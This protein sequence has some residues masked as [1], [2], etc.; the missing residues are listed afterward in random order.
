MCFSIGIFRICPANSW[1]IY[2]FCYVSIKFLFK[3]F[4][5]SCIWHT[6]QA[7][8]WHMSK[9]CQMLFCK[10]YKQSLTNSF[11]L[12]L[13]SP[14]WKSVPRNWLV[15]PSFRMPLSFCCNLWAKDVY[16]CYFFPAFSRTNTPT[17]Q[18]DN[19][20]CAWASLELPCPVS[21]RAADR[22]H[23][24][25]QHLRG[26]ARGASASMAG[27]LFPSAAWCCLLKMELPH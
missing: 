2:H 21:L 6:V 22:G 26:T 13:Q 19:L 17:K 8:I 16:F 15:I 1:A 5:R 14:L 12:L 4:T 23:G 10:W 7:C 3:K 9:K 20:S 24:A 27:K 18:L 25:M 11:L